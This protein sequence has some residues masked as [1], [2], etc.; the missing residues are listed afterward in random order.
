MSDQYLAEIR[1]FGGNFAPTALGRMRRSTSLDCPEHRLIRGDRNLLRRKRDTNFALPDLRGR[2]P[3][4]Q[5][6][7]QGLTPGLSGKTLGS[8]P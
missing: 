3:L 8:R 6:T 7:G 2:A 5:G 4:H 1:M